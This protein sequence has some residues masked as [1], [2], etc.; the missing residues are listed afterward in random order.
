AGATSVRID[1]AGDALV[2][3]A[4]EDSAAIGDL[5]VT[6]AGAQDG[7]LLRLDAA[8]TPVSALRIGGPGD[9]IVNS[10]AGV[11]AD[12]RLIVGAFQETAA[13]GTIDLTSAGDWDGFVASVGAQDTVTWALRIGGPGSDGV[14]SV[15]SA[16]GGDVIVA[17]TFTDV[18]DI[19]GQAL[20]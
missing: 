8:C 9:D 20:A 12:R 13:F 6:S 2:G 10:L 16:T 14:A 1:G 15:A 5:R 18:L 4:F 17:G 19:D 3:G 7:L 11:G